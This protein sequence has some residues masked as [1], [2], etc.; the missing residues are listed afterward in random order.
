MNRKL[1]VSLFLLISTLSVFYSNTCLAAP[2]PI[3]TAKKGVLNIL[4]IISDR[5]GNII[6]VSTGT[7]FLI[8]SNGYFLTNNHVIASD[9]NSKSILLV[10]DGNSTAE[11]NL[12]PAEVVWVSE[13]M[14]IAIIKA[15]GISERPNIRL[16]DVIP[17]LVD[18]NIYAIGFPGVSNSHQ[19]DEESVAASINRGDLTRIIDRGVEGIE[20]KVLQFDVSVNPGNSGGPLLDAC[21]RVIGINTQAISTD[22]GRIIQGVFYASHIQAAMEALKGENIDFEQDSTECIT[23][24]ASVNNASQAAS[25]AAEEKSNYGMIASI[26]G[27]IVALVAIIFSMKKP[28]ERI[29]HS[30]ESYTQYMRRGG[31]S[32]TSSP[33]K[34]QKIH[35]IPKAKKAPSLSP[36]PNSKQWILSGSI[37]RTGE[38]LSLTLNKNELSKGVILGRNRDLCDYSIPEKKLSRRHIRLLY[39]DHDIWVED[40]GSANGTYIDNR[41]VKPNLPQ[42]LSFGSE[43]N[44]AEAVVFTLS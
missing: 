36:P 35:S 34:K 40:L 6:A 26:F 33:P 19:L 39:K 21:G 32:S 18:N 15:Q 16:T 2:E 42:E 43:L 31:S 29:V 20:T 12:K 44:L 5:E 3:I 7:G 13:T 30:I 10:V 28:R 27:V 14:D 38:L 8:N 11:E 41:R 25:R 1:Y 22:N 37:M 9:G 4:N 23:E 17:K 24:I